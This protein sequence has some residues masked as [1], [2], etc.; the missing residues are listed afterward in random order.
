MLHCGQV[1]TEVSALL[2]IRSGIF[3]LLLLAPALCAGQL[4][5]APESLYLSTFLERQMVSLSNGRFS[6]GV[7]EISAGT[8]LWEGIGIEA[9]AGLGLTDDAIGS[10]EFQVKSQLAANLRLESPASGRV[11]AYGLLGYVRTRFSSGFSGVSEDDFKGVLSGYR[12]ALGLTY[13]LDDRWQ[14]DTGFTRH[15][16]AQNAGINSVRFESVVINAPAE[17]TGVNLDRQFT[18]Q[19]I[20]SD[21]VALTDLSDD[22]E[23]S[24]SNPAIATVS[25]T[26]TVRGIADGTVSISAR[27]GPLQDSF[28]L[29]VTSVALSAIAVAADVGAVDECDSVQFTATGNYGGEQTLI[30][31]V[32]SWE[33]TTADAGSFSSSDQPGLLRT[34][35]AVALRVNATLSGQSTPFDIT[36]LDNLAKIEI[37]EPDE[38]LSPSNPVQYA[39]IATFADKDERVDITDNVIWNVSSETGNYAEV[40][41]D[42]PG[43]G[44]VTA[45]ATGAGEVS[46]TCGG[47]TS[48]ALQILSGSPTLIRELFFEP[49]EIREDFTQDKTIGLQ[50]FVRFENGT[51]ENITDE[52]DWTLESGDS[53]IFSISND[54]ESKGELRVRG[55]GTAV[56]EA[57]YVDTNDNNTR[58]R[59]RITAVI[60]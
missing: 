59:A 19:A 27:F 44:T 2:N 4:R 60:Q 20:S 56:I 14:L 17:L 8:W 7:A 18:A 16:Y 38:T 43:R 40:D 55:T 58:K 9:E 49:E 34:R 50:V 57:S 3:G 13:Q 6:A 21:T 48:D 28:E 30:T 52:A 23:W 42:L 32:V 54:S 47:E 15:E 12:F 41:N 29:R 31:D 10:L 37:L 22:I 53:A 36:V 24:S 51:N 39:A 5:Q 46:A 11:A 45:S 25:N 35:K 26:G 33:V 1:S